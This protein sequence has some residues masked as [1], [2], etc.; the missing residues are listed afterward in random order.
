MCISA[1]AGWFG[2]FFFNTENELKY[3]SAQGGLISIWAAVL[4]NR[5]CYL[6]RGYYA[7]ESPIIPVITKSRLVLW[8][9]WFLRWQ[10][11]VWSLAWTDTNQVDL[12][13]LPGSTSGAWVD[14]KTVTICKCGRTF[15]CF[16]RKHHCRCCGN[17]FCEVQTINM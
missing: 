7:H 6:N 15:S 11:N 13:K 12:K 5:E 17:V 9:N 8:A 10:D 2:N 16:R 14:D 4:G 1:S 3:Y